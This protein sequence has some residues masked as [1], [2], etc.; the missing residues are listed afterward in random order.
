MDEE[1]SHEYTKR[2]VQVKAEGKEAQEERVVGHRKVDWV[3]L[4]PLQELLQRMDTI[5]R[6]MMIHAQMKK[7][8]EM[9]R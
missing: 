6:P 5:R 7:L 4:Q 3:L 8:Q 1:N 9:I 2:L